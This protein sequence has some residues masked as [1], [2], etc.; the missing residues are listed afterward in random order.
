MRRKRVLETLFFAAYTIFIFSL[1]SIPGKSIP[2]RITPYSLLFHFV[3][4]FFYGVVVFFFFW[5]NPVHSLAFGVLYAMSDEMHQ[6]FVPGRTCDPLD[7]L[8]DSIAL[9]ISILLLHL[10]LGK[11]LSIFRH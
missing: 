1:S 10:R 6:Y 9:L 8:V 11:R 2:S 5:K 4:Y 3:L 7:F